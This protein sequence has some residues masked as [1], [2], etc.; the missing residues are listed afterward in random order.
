M[1]YSNPQASTAS[2]E[3][4]A[5]SL[6][7]SDGNSRRR[8]SS[9]GFASGLISNLS[10]LIR[11]VPLGSSQPMDSSPTMVRP[12]SQDEA[13]VSAS[14]VELLGL[15]QLN[16]SS[17]QQPL[18]QPEPESKKLHSIRLTPFV[19]HTTTAPAL[20][21]GSVIRK[22]KPNH[23]ISIGRYTE[24]SRDAAHAPQGSSASVVFKSKVVSR[25]HAQFTVDSSGNWYIK[26]LKSSSGT[27]LNNQRLAPA[28]TESPL[29]RLQD[30]DILQLGIDFR[31]GTEET[32]RCVKMRVE[33]NK[34]W[35]RRAAK[36]SK[37]SYRRLQ[38]LS[39]PGRSTPEDGG[40]E[41]MECA[42]CLLTLEPCQAIFTSPC[43]HSWHYKCIR[44]MIVTS[45][46]Q[47]MCP[48]CRS[49][50]DL[51]AEAEEAENDS[52]LPD[53]DNKDDN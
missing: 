23:Q 24:K 8:G 27:F 18:P 9:L 49:V 46:P 19:D 43:S 32:F 28:N 16:S 37:E 30:G 36:F 3:G 11:P 33:L 53:L 12:I 48:N 5:L 38:Q 25:S 7:D 52:D 6:I 45:Y 41:P 4:E 29:F 47:F 21:F 51:E 31:G 2:L 40:V 20:Y 42:I 17:A 26:D 35:S 22:I 39:A 15:L 14:E 1:P 34:S 44:R 13:A 10:N 50:C